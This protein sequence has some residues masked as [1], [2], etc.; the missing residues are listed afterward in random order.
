MGPDFL[1]TV[2]TVNSGNDLISMVKI[3]P[4]F[5]PKVY[6][7]S[8]DF[9]CLPPMVSGYQYVAKFSIKSIDKDGKADTINLIATSPTSQNPLCSTIVQ[10]PVSQFPVE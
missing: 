10:V 8:P 6:M 9:I 5:N 4:K 2:Q 3:I 7:V 1:L